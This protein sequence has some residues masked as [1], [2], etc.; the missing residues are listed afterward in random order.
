MALPRIT[1]FKLLKAAYMAC[2]D[3]WE[4][5]TGGGLGAAA[6]F[7]VSESQDATCV[8]SYTQQES[9]MYLSVVHMWDREQ[10]Y[11]FVKRK[12]PMP[13]QAMVEDGH[14]YGVMESDAMMGEK[15]VVNC[16]LLWQIHNNH[17]HHCQARPKNKKHLVLHCRSLMR[18][19]KQQIN[20]WTKLLL[21]WEKCS[22]RTK[23]AEQ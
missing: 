10:K 16:P 2:M 4:L 23:Q 17:Q 20:M 5:V 7:S 18:V 15:L 6:N 12:V 11:A 13:C 3:K 8:V 22:N 9:L 14:V 21:S 19:V 1:I